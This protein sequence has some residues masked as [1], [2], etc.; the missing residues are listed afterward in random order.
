[1]ILWKGVSELSFLW[2]WHASEEQESFP[3]SPEIW[4]PVEVSVKNGWERT[5]TK[6]RWE[7]GWRDLV[8]LGL[9]MRRMALDWT[10]STNLD[11]QQFFLSIPF[12][13]AFYSY[14]FALH[15]L[16]I[17]FYCFYFFTLSIKAS[18]IP[19]VHNLWTT[20][21]P[22]LLFPNSTTHPRSNERWKNLIILSLPL[23]SFF[24]LL[25]LPCLELCIG[26]LFSR[27]VDSMRN[28]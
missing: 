5:M 18:F 4:M 17:Y 26:H 27:F 7:R 3:W 28:L 2:S 6:R 12:L 20:S 8:R 9:L 16:F 1:M 21:C 22:L 24:T 15:Y 25:F 23:H 11:L 13:E 19:R 10:L 14:T